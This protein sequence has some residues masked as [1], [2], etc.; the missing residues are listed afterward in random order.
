M[1]RWYELTD[2]PK[3]LPRPSAMIC[4]TTIYITDDVEGYSCP[5]G[6]VTGYCTKP[7][8]K[9][10]SWTCLPTLLVK[11]ATCATLCEQLVAVEDF[12]DNFNSLLSSIDNDVFMSMP[13][14]FVSSNT[15]RQL[16]DGK[17]VDIGALTRARRDCLLV[18][19]LPTKM[20]IV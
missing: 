5:I 12:Q 10:P 3:P 2:L 8:C 15:I 1:M 7:P 9:Q 20:L 11:N 4:G 19:P 18:S 14:C 13:S 16:V 17:W 6:D